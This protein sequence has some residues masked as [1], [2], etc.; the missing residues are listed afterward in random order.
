MHDRYYRWQ[1][2][3]PPTVGMKANLFFA[4]AFLVAAVAIGG[5]V[6]ERRDA[7]LMHGITQ[8]I[9]H[10]AAIPAGSP[11]SA[12]DAFFVAA[13]ARQ[14]GDARVLLACASAQSR[15]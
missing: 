11:V 6:Q 8:S 1:D 15:S 3:V 14:T 13:D 4:L 10:A 12:D 5:V 2:H 9:E 7:A